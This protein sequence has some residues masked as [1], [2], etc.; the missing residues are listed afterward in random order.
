MWRTAERGYLDQGSWTCWPWPTIGQWPIHTWAVWMVSWCMCMN[1]GHRC[2]Q[3]PH[4]DEAVHIR[5]HACLPFI[6][7]HPLFLPPPSMPG[8]QP[9]KVG[10]CWSSQAHNF[11]FESEALL[12]FCAICVTTFICPFFTPVIFHMWSLMPLCICYMANIPNIFWFYTIFNLVFFL[13]ENS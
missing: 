3:P 5:M 2:L 6:Q 9:G 7:N 12:F 11:V 10:K 8:H 13:A 1:G 4:T